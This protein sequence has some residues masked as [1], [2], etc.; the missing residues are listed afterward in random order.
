[1]TKPRSRRKHEAQIPTPTPIVTRSLIRRSTK[2][3]L[4]ASNSEPMAREISARVNPVTAIVTIILHHHQCLERRRVRLKRHNRR[5][6]FHLYRLHQSS[7]PSPPYQRRRP[8]APILH[9]LHPPFGQIHQS[10]LFR[11]KKRMLQRPLLPLISRPA[12][13][14]R[15]PRQTRTFKGSRGSRS[16]SHAFPRIRRS[17]RNSLATSMF[18]TTM[19]IVPTATSL[20]PRVKDSRKRRTRRRE[21]R[22]HMN[23]CL[24]R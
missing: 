9:P 6:P 21:V 17:T 18:R 8:N 14:I 13:S 2:A 20:S 10:S 7:A 16:R 11:R 3:R 23:A 1:M 5:S 12:V 22:F 19:L 15:C 4:R 24:L